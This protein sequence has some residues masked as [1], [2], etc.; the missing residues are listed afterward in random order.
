MLF[1]YNTFDDNGRRRGT[2]WFALL[3]VAWLQLS[4][5]AHAQDHVVEQVGDSCQVCLQLD[6]AD[7]AAADHASATAIAPGL[8]SRVVLPAAEAAE[9]AV[10]R[11]FD[12]R[13][14]PQL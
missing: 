3:S 2:V 5:A 1:G 10:V 13:A 7:D 14:P 4:S 6:R 12:A 9:C 11:E 8:A